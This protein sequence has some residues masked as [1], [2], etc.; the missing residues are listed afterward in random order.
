MSE[1]LDPSMLI[2]IVVSVYRLIFVNLN[3]NLEMK[4]VYEQDQQKSE[5]L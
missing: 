5:D 1:E 2:S 3:I 4:A